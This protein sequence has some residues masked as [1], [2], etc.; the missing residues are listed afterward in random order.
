MG[1]TSSNKVVVFEGDEN[2]T[3]KM[4]DVQITQANGFSLCGTP[5]L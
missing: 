2:L 4:F 3:G 1:R 5:A